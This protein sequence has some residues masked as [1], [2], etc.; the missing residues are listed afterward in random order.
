MLMQQ[1]LELT[2]D[3]WASATELF[4]FFLASVLVAAAINALKLD[5]KVV[6]S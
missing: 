5:R 1:F 6:R 2:A 3:F 4:W